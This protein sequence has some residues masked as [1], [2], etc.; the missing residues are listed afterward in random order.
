MR[1]RPRQTVAVIVRRSIWLPVSQG[2]L[3]LHR[4]ET[5][6]FNLTVSVCA[7]STPKFVV[8]VVTCKFRDTPLVFLTVFGADARLRS[9]ALFTGR[10][11]DP[12]GPLPE[13]S[14]TIRRARRVSFSSDFCVQILTSQGL[15]CVCFC[16]LLY[17]WSTADLAACRNFSYRFRR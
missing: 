12:S 13:A 8:T 16:G 14:S 6:G 17:R 7:P 1:L 10:T 3:D 9:W 11:G 15:F 2:Q 5:S 4:V